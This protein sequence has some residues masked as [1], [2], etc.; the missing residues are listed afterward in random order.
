MPSLN[1]HS[2]A[3]CRRHSNLLP[4]RRAPTE[5]EKAERMKKEKNKNKFCAIIA[6]NQYIASS[7]LSR[8]LIEFVYLCIVSLSTR[9]NHFLTGKQRGRNLLCL[10]VL[11]VLYIVSRER[12]AQCFKT[13]FLCAQTNPIYRKIASGQLLCVFSAS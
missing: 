6:G 1:A 7:L 10:P 11:C 2:I 12:N 13:K 5:N 3:R 8:I 4:L 9:H